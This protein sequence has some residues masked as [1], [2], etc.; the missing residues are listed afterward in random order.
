MSRTEFSSRYL[1][2]KTNKSINF[3]F[4]I[5]RENNLYPDYAMTQNNTCDASE[6]LAM[7]LLRCNHTKDK[8]CPILSSKF[9]TMPANVNYSV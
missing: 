3:K 2:K 6:V 5:T 7:S 8:I 4:N 9:V 1:T